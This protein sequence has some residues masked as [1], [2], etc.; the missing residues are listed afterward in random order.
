MNY[1]V[2]PHEHVVPVESPQEGNRLLDITKDTQKN[3]H[4]REYNNESAESLEGE[5]ILCN[6][7]SINPCL[8]RYPFDRQGQYPGH[9]D[10][11]P[12][13]QLE[14]KIYPRENC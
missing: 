12:V 7:I 1:K 2:D 6:R 11:D 10:E 5:R 14:G 9:F 4:R 3:R 8:A 13:G